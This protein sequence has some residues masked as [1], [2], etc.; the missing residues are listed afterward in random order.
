[1]MNCEYCAR[2]GQQVPSTRVIE[3]TPF[4]DRCFHG[5]HPLDKTHIPTGKFGRPQVLDD[6]QLEEAREAIKQ[7]QTQRGIAAR[8]GCSSWVIYRIKRD[9]VLAGEMAP[10]NRG[11]YAR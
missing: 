9:M 8:Y 3:G 11:K 5:A 7:G 1:M 2:Y 10:E 4:C 6:K